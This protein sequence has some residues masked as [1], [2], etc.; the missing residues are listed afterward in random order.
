MNETDIGPRGSRARRKRTGG[1]GGALVTVNPFPPTGAEPIS[2]YT[3]P[4]VSSLMTVVAQGAAR[5][6]KTINVTSVVSG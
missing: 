6:Q 5:T 2:S 1:A 3:I 4:E